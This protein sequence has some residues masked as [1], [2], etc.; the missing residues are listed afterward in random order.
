EQVVLRRD[1][2]LPDRAAV[3]VVRAVRE[4]DDRAGARQR[5]ADRRRHEPGPRVV[6]GRP[7]TAIRLSPLLRR[8][9]AGRRE[10][11]WRLLPH[12]GIAIPLSILIFFPLLCGV[13][14]ALTP[15]GVAPGILW[16]G[17]IVPL[18]YTVM[19]SA[20]FDAG[21]GLQHIPGDKWIPALGIRYKL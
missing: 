3:R 6:G 4:L 10:R 12:L 13:L 14:A 19:M 5:R 2:R 21:A 15:R 8:A 9:A 18:V 20:D 17:T 11:S 16:I 1:H 7:R